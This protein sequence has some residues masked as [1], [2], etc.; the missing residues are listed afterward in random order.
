MRPRAQPALLLLLFVRAVVPQARPPLAPSVTVTRHMSSATTTLRCRALHFYPPNI[1]MQW[2]KDRQPLEAKDVELR[3]MLPNGDG[4]YQ[5]RVA[6]TV[7]YGEE[8][9][10]TCWV[11][12]PGLDQPI[13]ATWEPSLSSS[14]VIGIASGITVCVLTIFFGI[15][16]QIFKKRQASRGALGDYVLAECQ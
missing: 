15:L 14:L 1:T 2:L 12:H 3:T 10:F 6:L 4:T 9:R 5:A 16:Y 13:A 11:E 8:Q 7:P